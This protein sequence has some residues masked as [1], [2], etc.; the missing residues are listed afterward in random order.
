[1]VFTVFRIPSNGIEKEPNYYPKQK[2]LTFVIDLMSDET[3]R[4]IGIPRRKRDII[5]PGTTLEQNSHVR[6]IL[7][8][9]RRLIER[10]IVMLDSGSRETFTFSA[11]TNRSTAQCLAFFPR[12]SPF[13]GLQTCCR[14]QKEVFRERLLK[15]FL[16]QAVASCVRINWAEMH[17]GTK[18]SKSKKKFFKFFH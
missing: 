1:M 13:G 18:L 8:A 11:R 10:S 9:R 4:V 2:T 16:D 7:P 5:F 14:K 3:L 12:V 15:L 17:S 6:T